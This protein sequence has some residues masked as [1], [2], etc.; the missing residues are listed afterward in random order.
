MSLNFCKWDSK[1]ENRPIY[2]SGRFKT[3]HIFSQLLRM[4][5]TQ[6]FDSNATIRNKTGKMNGKNRNLTYDTELLKTFCAHLGSVF[7]MK[8]IVVNFSKNWF[9]LPNWSRAFRHVDN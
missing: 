8:N 9:L 7:I 5:S 6:R 4:P 1:L 3:E 2:I